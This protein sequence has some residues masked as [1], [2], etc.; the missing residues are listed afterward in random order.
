MRDRDQSLRTARLQVHG[1]ADAVGDSRL[2]GEDGP[3]AALEALREVA[4]EPLA[5]DR[6]LTRLTPNEN[7]PEAF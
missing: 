2:T 6:K 3:V 1:T 4:L 7:T 5:Y